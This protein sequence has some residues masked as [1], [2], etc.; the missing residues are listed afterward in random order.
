MTLTEFL[1]SLRGFTNFTD[2][3]VQTDNVLT[4]WLRMG[5]SR[6]NSELRIADMV[7]IDTATITTDRVLAPSDFIAADFVIGPDGLP[8]TYKPRDEYYRI[9]E[10]TDR[11][12]FYTTSGNYL[13][14]GG[15]PDVVD[16]KEVELHYFGDIPALT[17]DANWVSNRYSLL[18]VSA[19]MAVASMGMIE[20]EQAV[21]WEAATDKQIKVLNDRYTSSRAAGSKLSRKVRGFG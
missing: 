14:F 20:P 4:G 5:E 19:T 13:I 10:G 8:W 6:V 17:G 11:E 2:P 16:G 15:E 9:D 12:G 18:L 21:V 3:T 1:T 7:Q